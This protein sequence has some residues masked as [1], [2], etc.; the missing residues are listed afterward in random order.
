MLRRDFLSLSSLAFGAGVQA[1]TSPA[2]LQL[3]KSIIDYGAKPDG[4]TLNTTAIQHAID[5]ISGAGGGTVYAP[6]GIFL[7]GGLELKSGVTLYLEAGCVLLGSTSIDDYSYHPGPPMKG[8]A[9]GHHLLFSDN[10]ENV[11]I[12]GAGTID[13]QGPAYWQP[14]PA[15][16]LRP[17]SEYWRDV[18][19]QQ[20][21]AI[22]NNLRPSP[23]IEFARCRNVRIS[24]VS[25]KNSAGWT[26]RLVA[27]QSVTIDGIRIRNPENGVNTDG[28][29]IA[30]SQNVLVSNCD[31][32]T[33]DDAICLKSENPYG[34]LLPTRN[35]VVTNCIL[36]TPCNGFKI[37]TATKGP[38]ENIAFDNSTI[39]ANAGSPL[40]RRPIA[41]ISI[42]VVDGG[43][44]D[45]VVISNI[46]MQNVRAPIFVR[47]GDRQKKS[48][49]FLRN[50]SIN[51][52]DVTG[53]I[54]TSSITGVPGLRPSDISISN[55]RVRTDEQGEEAWARRE[56]PEVAEGYPDA[57]M[58]GRLPSYGFFIRHADRIRLRNV[59]CIAGK[60]DA[61]PALI[62]DDTDDLI[63][64]GLELDAPAGDAAVIELKN[65]QQVFV[66]GMRMPIG[67]KTLAQIEGASSSGISFS[68]NAFEPASPFV[69]FTNGATAA[70]LG[71]Q[72]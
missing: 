22:N 67:A 11:G 54:L 9:N 70:A 41:G 55:C 14:K 20:F 23:M 71:A 1:A 16:S 10:C 50:V 38:I 40:N 45:G 64:A 31:I 30:C 68:G 21:E 18:Y 52:I 48:G 35:I 59:E 4:K 32:E 43:S 58:M 61:R 49:S 36:T 15:A 39:Y 65:T 3:A 6:P 66:S 60:P 53:S 17:P 69:T 56:I 25:L 44:L 63:L 2:Q 42:S 26:L 33:G 8:D 37:G 13:G 12:C 34:D 27:S 7:T 51:N 46:R 57:Y 62:C 19:S 28:I 72:H 29:D 5:D 24:G 47:L